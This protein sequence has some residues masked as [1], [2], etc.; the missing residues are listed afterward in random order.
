MSDS[1]ASETS[2]EETT[3]SEESAGRGKPAPLG[4]V[5]EDE[6]EQIEQERSERLDPDN[7]PDNA[8]VDNTERDFDTEHGEFTDADH[9]EQLGPFSSDEV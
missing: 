5:S 1:S 6:R 4:E 9:D 8:E 3:D 7:R 2:T